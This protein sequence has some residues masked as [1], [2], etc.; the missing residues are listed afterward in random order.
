MRF[1]DLWSSIGVVT[2]DFGGTLAG[3]SLD[4][5]SY[6][7][8]LLRYLQDLGYRVDRSSL[9]G[10]IEGMLM[11]LEKARENN[12]ELR[13]EELYFNVFHTLGIRADEELLEDIYRLYLKSYSF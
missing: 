7:A 11:K 1:I 3:G 13:F 10:A 9:S 4:R 6:R 2:L 5:M 12:I 8:D